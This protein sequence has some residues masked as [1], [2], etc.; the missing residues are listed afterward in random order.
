MSALEIFLLWGQLLPFGDSRLF[1]LLVRR[2][3]SFTL[4]DEIHV[5]WVVAECWRE[6]L[7]EH[8]EMAHLGYVDHVGKLQHLQSHRL[9]GKRPQILCGT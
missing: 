9:E 3:W 6:L 1:A 4:S 8:G 2:G 7:P 5:R